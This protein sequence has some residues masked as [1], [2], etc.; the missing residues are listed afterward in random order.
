MLPANVFDAD[1]QL[2]NFL[3]GLSG[4]SKEPVFVYQKDKH[5]FSCMTDQTNTPLTK[6]RLRE[7]VLLRYLMVVF[8]EKGTP[9]M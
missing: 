1:L 5:R 7:A 3:R 4:I 6:Q 9:Q 2:N 8:I